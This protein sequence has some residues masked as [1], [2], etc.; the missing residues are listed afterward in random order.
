MGTDIHAYLQRKNKKTGKWEPL[1]L[2]VDKGNGPEFVNFYIG[3][4]YLLFGQLAGVRGYVDQDPIVSPRGLPDELCNFIAAEYQKGA[5]NDGSDWNDYH[6]PGWLDYVELKMFA[7]DPKNV[8]EDDWGNMRNP[9]AEL[10][11]DV[12]FVL[13]KYYIWDPA[14]GELQL[15]FWFDS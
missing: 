12:K 15:V 11:E 4:D 10:Y 1:N 5:W 6:T 13:D 7:N 9:I 3:R 8:I 2:Y 14:P